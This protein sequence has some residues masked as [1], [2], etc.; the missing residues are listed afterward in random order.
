MCMTQKEHG[1]GVI[2][3]AGCLAPPGE[4]DH[5]INAHSMMT[6]SG[7][8][9]RHL[10]LLHLTLGRPQTYESSLPVEIQPILLLLCMTRVIRCVYFLLEP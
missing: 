5:E 9:E 6:E 8:E 7:R 2:I 4:G 1:L 10:C 3:K